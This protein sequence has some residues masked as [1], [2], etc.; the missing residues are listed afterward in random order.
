MVAT[1]RPYSSS[2]IAAMNTS[3]IKRT[4]RLAGIC[5]LIMGLAALLGFYHAPLINL[6][7]GTTERALLG[8]AARFR[9]GVVADGLAA[10]MAIPVAVLLSE[11]FSRV[12]RRQATLLGVLLVTAVPVS[13]VVALAYVGAAWLLGSD[14]AFAAMPAET[15]ETLGRLLLR[16]HEHGVLAVEIFWGLWLLPFGTLIL[17]SRML[18]RLLGILLLI[19]GVA[20]VAHSLVSLLLPGPRLAGYERVTMLARGAAEFPTM[21]W[22]LLAGARAPAPAAS[23]PPGETGAPG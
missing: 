22:L 16:L 20:Y 9:V 13:F 11:L 4:A 2:G 6:D 18:P 19:G 17:R 15:R 21:L 3:A 7:V 5:Y 12:S 23:Q 1:P 10:V 8:S 14:P